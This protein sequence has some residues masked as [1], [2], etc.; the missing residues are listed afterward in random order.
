LTR[1]PS[2]EAD[3]L[4]LAAV[5]DLYARKVACWSMKASLSRKLV[6]D[7]LLIVVWRRKPD[8][9][10]IV[11]SDQGSQYGCDDFRRFCR[12]QNLD[13]SMSRRGN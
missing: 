11:H 2:T 1:K 10:V 5:L 3:Q 12:T 9:A 8:R 7:A 6:L 13:P 4:H